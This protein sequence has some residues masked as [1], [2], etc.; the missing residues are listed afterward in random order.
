M[1]IVAISVWTCGLDWSGI[2]QSHS[3]DIRG[4][5]C[6]VPVLQMTVAVRYVM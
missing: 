2:Q 3:R 6:G 4:M 5:S 1:G